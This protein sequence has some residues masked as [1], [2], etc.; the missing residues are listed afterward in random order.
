[1]YSLYHTDLYPDKDGI[2]SRAASLLNGVATSFPTSV[3]FSSRA[4]QGTGG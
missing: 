3:I 1:M 2:S 4:L